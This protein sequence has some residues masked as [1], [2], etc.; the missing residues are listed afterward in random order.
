MTTTKL[1]I[2]KQVYADD[3][4]NF[5]AKKI[6]NLAAPVDGGDAV[7]K[8][9]ADGIIAAADAM[10]FKGVVDCST[11]PNYPAAD[12]GW[13]YKVSV[14][15]KIGGVSG[16]SVIPGDELLCTEDGTASGDQATVG[17][18]WDVVHVEGTGV[19]PNAPITGATKTRI[20][21]DSKGLVTTGEDATTA[22]IA[23]S[24]NRRYMTEAEKTVLDNTSGT[25]TGD[26]TVDS[27]GALINS[28]TSKSTPADADAFAVMNSADSNKL[29]SFTW[30][31]LKAA[32]KSFLMGT[33][34]V[35]EVPAGNRDGFNVTFSLANAPIAG[36]EMVFLNGLLQNSGSGND[37]TISGQN[38]T[39]ASAPVATDVI[40][41]TY[42]R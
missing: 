38:I 36:T 27:I 32:I 31:N 30:A 17:A 4:F 6:T 34:M 23:D 20:T 1:R 7:N 8:A 11:N 37:Y 13:T 16:V 25:N 42:W 33:Y 40:L 26:E 10:V 9:Y 2:T 19:V 22:D 41:V 3:D 29:A 39:M 5:N 15:G 12:C 14:A 35:R 18:K 21:Y 24:L 28:G